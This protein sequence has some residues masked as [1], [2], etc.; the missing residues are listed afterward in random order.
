MIAVI[1]GDIINSRSVHTDIWLPK[2]KTFFS[3]VS[4]ESN[5]WEVFRGDSFQLEIEFEKV[6]EVV[7]CI[8]ALIKTNSKIDVRMAIGIGEK[9][10]NGVKI[11]ESNGSAFINS[12]EAFEQLKNNTLLLK[13]LNQ[14]F[15][16]F[17]NPILKLVDFISSN[18]KPVAAETIFFALTHPTLKQKEIAV[19][20]SKDN[21]TISKALKRGA[22]DEI[23]D[24]LNLYHKKT[25]Q[26]FT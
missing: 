26:W 5:T 4:S 14:E 12:G 16:D 3:S 11:S 6:L 24:V 25:K 18:W 20:L 21:T 9:E 13:S 19:Q 7:L 1:T 17:F 15:D 2:L 8:K 22:Y 23:M 10:Y